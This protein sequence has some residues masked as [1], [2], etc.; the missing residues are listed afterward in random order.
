MS[1]LQ[2]LNIPSRD[3]CL[4][5]FLNAKR[6]KKLSFQQ[7]ADKLGR[8]KVWVAAALL[9]NATFEECD[10]KLLG[11][12]LNI[13]NLDELIPILLEPPF[14]KPF[15]GSHSVCPTD[16]TLYRFYEIINVYGESFK[17][18][19]NEECG[20]GIMSAVGLKV[21]FDLE[22]R[23]DGDHI[24]ITLDGKFLPYKKW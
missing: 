21:N 8:D 20:D 22:K 12:I 6:K 11:G 7:I 10:L 1:N 18:L 17:S 24:L 13:E 15:S 16:P 3:D 9:G 23:E 4:K 2:I 14:R 19:I 5:I